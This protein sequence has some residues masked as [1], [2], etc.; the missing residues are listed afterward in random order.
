MI[1]SRGT[2]DELKEMINAA[3]GMELR[4]LLNN[5]H[6]NTCK[7][8]LDGTNE[9]DGPDHLYFHEGG[10]GRHELWDSCRFN[11]AILRYLL[12]NLRFY[13]DEYQFDGFRFD[14]VTSMMYTHHGMGADFSGGSMNI[15]VILTI[16]NLMLVCAL[17]RVLRRD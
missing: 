7:N 15:L 16:L 8:V 2:P 5:V 11:Y 6:S 3:H 10:K 13:M 4:V 1:S 9:F 17:R 14:S 12:C